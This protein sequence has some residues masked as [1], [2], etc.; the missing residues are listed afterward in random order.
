MEM[1]RVIYDICQ[2]QNTTHIASWHDALSNCQLS[3][4]QVAHFIGLRLIC[5]ASTVK[6]KKSSLENF[7]TY[8]VFCSSYIALLVHMPLLGGSCWGLL[9]RLRRENLIIWK[10]KACL[11]NFLVLTAIS[12]YSIWKC[13]YFLSIFKEEGGWKE[14]QREGKCPLK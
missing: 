10:R 6:K 1:L 12:L 9:L 3:D 2:S 4:L 14:L 7:R 11:R 5:K 8:E 13:G